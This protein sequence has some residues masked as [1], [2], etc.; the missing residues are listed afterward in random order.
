[1]FVILAWQFTLL[2][3]MPAYVTI[4]P[5]ECLGTLRHVCVGQNHTRHR[6]RLDGLNESVSRLMKMLRSDSAA[7]QV[8]GDL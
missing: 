6:C 8:Q 3:V 4:L 7:E 1:M 5:V 2:P